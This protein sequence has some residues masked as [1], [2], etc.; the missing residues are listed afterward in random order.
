MV[1]SGG[2]FMAILEFYFDFWRLPFFIARRLF[3][4][5]S[6]SIIV[7]RCSTI[8]CIYFWYCFIL[9]C[10]TLQ[11]VYAGDYEALHILYQE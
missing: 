9:F 7:M 2:L 3:V 10:T 11:G 4:L 8:S 6:K 5:E 1:K